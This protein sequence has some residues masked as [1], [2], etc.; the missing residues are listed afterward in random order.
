MLPR[1]FHKLRRVLD[2]RQPDLTVLM[3][4]VN[5]PHNLSAILRNC[6]AVGVLEAH[7]VAP[8]GGLALHHETSGGTSKWIEVHRHRDALSAIRALRE[9]GHQVVAAH[10][11]DGAV[12]FRRVD[13]TSPTAVLLGAEL[14]GVSEEARGAADFTVR[15]PM[16]GM[17][18]SLN[19]SV[20]TAL[21]LYRAYEQREAAGMY[22]KPSL[23]PERR[24]RLLF[25]WAYPQI[26]RALKAKGAAYPELG[27][28]GEFLG[29]LDSLRNDHDQGSR[30]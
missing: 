10:P 5:K 23:E 21:L 17:A 25:E 9:R 15:I 30:R 22:D 28:D 6:D 14:H 29:S 4:K 7:A 12:D 16:V 1:R 3:E 18:G 13:F 20:A 19:V 8:G 26:A 24:D 2:R 11:D 27:P